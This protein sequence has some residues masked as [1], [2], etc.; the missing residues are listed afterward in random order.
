MLRVPARLTA[1]TVAGALALGLTSLGATPVGAAQT[2]VTHPVVVSTNP[3]DTTPHVLDGQTEAVL[4][5]GSRVLVGGSFSQVKRWSRPEVL[6]RT[7]LFAYDKAT[8]V[9]D[10]TFAPQLS[11]KVTALL[12]APDGMVYVAGQAPAHLPA[13]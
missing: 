2:G 10:P 6:T 5:L 12:A 13:A 1:L 9:V 3:V 7:H 4:D 8:G 11:G